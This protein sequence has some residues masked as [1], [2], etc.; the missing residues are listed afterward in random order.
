MNCPD[1]GAA[2][3]DNAVFCAQCGRR[4][5]A[6]AEAAPAEAAAR[7]P[8]T[9]ASPGGSP[10]PE[11][12]LWSGAYSPQA[13][14]GTWVAAGA[15]SIALLILAAVIGHE[16]KWRWIWPVVLGAIALLAAGVGSQLA[17][18]KLS[19]HYRLTNQRLFYI[20][21]I[22]KRTTDLIELIN[23]NDVG[24][25]QGPVER[26]LTGTGTIRIYSKDQSH[27]KL[28]MQGIADVV[29]VVDVLDNARRAER[30][31]RG[32][33]MLGGELRADAVDGGHAS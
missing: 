4:I 26:M 17:Y 21:G 11:E 29:K 8:F 2:V 1:C 12:D 22:L 3:A 14:L 32:L 15:I 31:R 23:I 25:E 6:P 28:L 16:E 18:R 13:M 19:I 33:Q 24:F 10:L 27:P 9:P 5:A 7:H 30:R 20:S